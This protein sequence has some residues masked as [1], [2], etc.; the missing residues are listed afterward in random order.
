LSGNNRS[1]GIP[2]AQFVTDWASAQPRPPPRCRTA[3]KARLAISLKV[4]PGRSGVGAESP[5]ETARKLDGEGYFDIA[6]RNW[7]LESLCLLEV[8]IGLA[9]GDGAISGQSLGGLGPM[10]IPLQ[11]GA[12]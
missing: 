1:S 6:D 9:L 4:N 12:G 11:K 5:Y 10:L 3:R 8:A 7:V 2:D